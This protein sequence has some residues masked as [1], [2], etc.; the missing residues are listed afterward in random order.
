MINLFSLNKTASAGNLFSAFRTVSLLLF[1]SGSFFFSCCTTST[2]ATVSREE[3]A[4]FTEKVS[5]RYSSIDISDFADGFNH[6]RY[7][8]PNSIPP[9]GLYDTDQIAGF[10]ENMVY[11]QNPDGGWAKNLDFQRKYSLAELLQLQKENKSI[12]PVTYGLKTDSKG[13]TIDNGNIFSQIKYLAQ[14]CKQIEDQ[15]YLD[16]MN[17]AIQWIINAQHPLSGGFTGAD[18]F[19]ITYND[20]VM[21]ETLR[22]LKNIAND[23]SLYDVVPSEMR[24]KAREAYNKGIECVLKTQITLTLSDGRKIL[25]AWCQQHSHETFVPVWA[26]EFEP[27]CVCTN[28]SAKLVDFLMEEENPSDDIKTAVIAA[29]NWFDMDQVR[30]HHKKI[31]KNPAEGEVLNGRYYDYDQVL[32]DD[33]NAS[34]LWARFYALDS[35]FDV[36]TGARKPIQG[37]YPAVNTPIWCDR[38]CKYCETFNDMSKERRNGYGYTGNR[39]A[40]TLKNFAA[41][42]SRN[43]L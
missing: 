2:Q 24:A 25:T 14:V 7:Q 26:R 36:V 4:E 34:D 10:A 22:T 5:E 23:D 15:R 11:L 8:Y 37:T 18:V 27:P 9:W 32:V 39:P 28:E 1:L 43:A 30:I 38:G 42:K 41:W 33:E 40:K 31:V 16:C 13:S 21:T 12:T 29:C 3:E 19:A 20:D 35:S 6:A 17:K